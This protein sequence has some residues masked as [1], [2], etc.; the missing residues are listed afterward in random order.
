MHVD[1]NQL[2]YDSIGLSNEFFFLQWLSLVLP[3]FSIYMDS[4]RECYEAYVIYN[5][6]MFVM[7]ALCMEMDLLAVM[8]SRSATGQ[9]KHFFPFCFLRDWDMGTE[10]VYKCK[11]GILQYAF[12]QPIITVISV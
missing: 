7:E 8:R 9:I 3:T 4:I 6:M 10:F 11:H 5:F 2:L 12:F 1:L